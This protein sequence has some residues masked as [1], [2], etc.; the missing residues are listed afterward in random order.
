MFSLFVLFFC[1]FKKIQS[2]DSTGDLANIAAS[3]SD[4]NFK[5]CFAETQRKLRDFEQTNL[6]LIQSNMNLKEEVQLLQN[7]VY[8][9]FKLFL[10]HLQVNRLGCIEAVPIQSSLFCAMILYMHVSM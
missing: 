6:G 5:K 10:Y 4:E 2:V 3:T 7:M 8:L 9:L 1:F